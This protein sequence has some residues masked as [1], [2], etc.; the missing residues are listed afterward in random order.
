METSVLSLILSKDCQVIQGIGSGSVCTH[1]RLRSLVLSEF[2]RTFNPPSPLRVGGLRGDDPHVFL[3]RSL[4]F[5][6]VL[7]SSDHGLLSWTPLLGLAIL[8]LLFF[9]FRLPKAGIP[10]FTALVAF[11]L[12][13]SLFPDWAG[14][15]PYGN[16]F[17]VSLTPPFILGLAYV[18][19]RVAAHFPQPRV[20][21]AVS[22][23]MLACFVLWN[24]GFIYQWGTHLVPA[25]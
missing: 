7:F 18:L 15:S 22:S 6:S 8:G 20:A 10:F 13:I 24:L 11:Y 3:W 23:G 5:F 25:I 16:R 1:S 2:P 19:E 21:L 12:F 9:T 17:F 14:I 4:V